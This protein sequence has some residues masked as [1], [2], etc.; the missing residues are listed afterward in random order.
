MGAWVQKIW[1]ERGTEN[2]EHRTQN[3]EQR[4]HNAEQKTR[5]RERKRRNATHGRGVARGAPFDYDVVRTRRLRDYLKTPQDETA[6]RKRLR[7]SGYGAHA[8]ADGGSA[9]V[10]AYT[11]GTTIPLETVKVRCG[12]APAQRGL[13]ALLD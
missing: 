5:N 12:P 7:R 2:A 1:R 4:M 3:A 8:K 6:G 13:P 11:R 10:R 9:V